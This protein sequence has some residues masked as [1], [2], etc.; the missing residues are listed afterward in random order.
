MSSASGA[1]DERVLIVGGSVSKLT[2][3]YVLAELGGSELEIWQVVGSDSSEA[4][5][6]VRQRYEPGEAVLV[7][8]TGTNDTDPRVLARNLRRAARLVGDACMVVP[9]VEREVGGGE[10]DAKNRAIFEFAASRPGTQTPEWSGVV[11]MRP[12]LLLEPQGF[13][14]NHP[15]ATFRAKLVSAAIRECLAFRRGLE[16]PRSKPT[17]LQPV[18]L[19]N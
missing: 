8:D 2:T 18:R 14:Q 16:P 17:W 15:A 10:A 4:V 12:E 5:E 3:P 9:T 1:G 11:E 6:M 7:F 13:E 19:P